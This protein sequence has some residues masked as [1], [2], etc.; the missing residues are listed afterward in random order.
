MEPDS[1]REQP[2]RLLQLPEAALALVLQQLLQED[3]HSLLCMV[4]SCSQLSTT[5]A[6]SGISKITACCRKAAAAKSFM[7][8]LERHSSSLSDLI[9]CSIHTMFGQSGKVLGRLPCPQLRRL[10][11]QGVELLS[12]SSGGCPSMLQDCTGLTTL[13]LQSCKVDNMS[14]VLSASPQL[15]CLEVV[16]SRDK[17]G[18]FAFA[19]LQHPLNFKSLSLEFYQDKFELPQHLEQLSA[20]VNLELL[21]LSALHPT[22]LPD[23]LPPQ[24]TNLTNLRVTYRNRAQ[25]DSVAE[26]FKHLSSFTALQSLEV[27]CSSTE[28]LAWSLPGIGDLEKLTCINFKSDTLAFRTVSTHRWSQLT[29]LESLTLHGCAVQPSALA[30]FTQLRTLQLINTQPLHNATPQDLVSAVSKL[31]LLTELHAGLYL[32]RNRAAPQPDA[33]A[34]LTA[35]T[36]LRFLEVNLLPSDRKIYGGPVVLFRPDTLYPHMQRVDL[37]CTGSSNL[38]LSEPQLQLL[39][40]SCPAVSSLAFALIKDP[41]AAACLP[42]LQLP[43]LTHLLICGLDKRAGA[44]AAV[45]AAAQLTR[46]QQLSLAHLN[47]LKEHLVDP[48]LVKLTA[49][50]TLTELQLKGRIT[51]ACQRMQNTVSAR[52][53][54]HC[55]VCCSIASCK[56]GRAL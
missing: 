6:Y 16:H 38:R 37:T 13:S 50:T 47:Q 48:T 22:A 56:Q 44:A 21:S 19:Q 42:L 25:V 53:P 12:S 10:R 40:S 32:H 7:R 36:N 8:W 51:T 23:G 1:S 54:L 4:M 49:R 30:T 15:Q 17:Q 33:F 24:L 41:S 39:C 9:E 52:R 5:P 45:D 46:L 2:N 3:P 35:S 34:A 29:A 55:T 43:A 27:G 11:L 31:Q 20:L 28:D 14:A 26:Q 18:V